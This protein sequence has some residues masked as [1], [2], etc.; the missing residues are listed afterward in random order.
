M[1]ELC[2][3][4]CAKRKQQTCRNKAGAPSGA[5][6]DEDLFAW[7]PG[8]LK[9]SHLAQQPTIATRDQIIGMPHL[10]LSL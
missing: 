8:P 4:A 3:A 10:I 7:L 1:L 6:R 9:H 2:P 5:P